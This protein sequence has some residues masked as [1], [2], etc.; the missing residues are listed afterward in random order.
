MIPATTSSD[1]ELVSHNDD[2][3]RAIEKIEEITATAEQST[4]SIEDIEK[5]HEEMVPKIDDVIEMTKNPNNAYKFLKDKGI[6]RIVI[7]NLDIPNAKAK[8]QLLLLLKILFDIAPTTI[9]A[10]IPINVVDKLLDIF[11]NEDNL[12][13]KAH[14]LDIL[15]VWLPENPK[16]QARVMKL[17]GLEP[18]YEQ[19][20]KLDT[21]VIHTL[22]DLFNKIVKEHM[23]IRNNKQLRNKIDTDKLSL[24]QRI[25]LIERLSTTPVCNG[26]LNIFEDTWSYSTKDN[27]VIVPVL[28]LIIKIKPFCLK[29]FQGKA[30][31]VE[32]FDALLKFVKEDETKEYL[33]SFNLNASDVE[34]TLMEYV[35]F[36]KEIK[37]E[38]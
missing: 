37:D 12:A 17:K 18:F 5:L 14:V 28:D 21:N 34:R 23:E 11:E 33:E 8:T 32:L 36:F 7:P 24:Y 10:V 27:D 3:S 9:N 6:D 20:S 38:L 13:L 4:L 35:N 2:L 15:Y 26:L 29:K 19:I 31:A 16:V 30:K 1:T 22:L 25:G